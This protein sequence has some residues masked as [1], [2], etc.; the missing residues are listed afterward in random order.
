MIDT[1]STTEMNR[2]A[3]NTA[4]GQPTLSQLVSG[5]ADD[6]QRLIQQQYH[7]FRA[8][9]REDMRRTKA[10]V[11]YLGVGAGLAMVGVVFLL[12]SLPLLLNWA[13]NWEPWGGW[14]LMGGVLLVGGGI[15]LYAGK[16]IF[17]K[18]NPLP[19]KTLNALEENISW[20]ANRQK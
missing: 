2:Q 3:L 1:P 8:E 19:D 12:V 7:M 11:Q 16:R 9:V 13:F 14:A 10:A 15:A 5:I 4:D 17:D 6:A 20:I 18:N